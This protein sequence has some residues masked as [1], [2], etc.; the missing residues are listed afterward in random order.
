MKGKISFIEQ[1]QFLHLF[2]AVMLA[3][4]TWGSMGLALLC[5]QSMNCSLSHTSVLV[6]RDRQAGC[7]AWSEYAFFSTRLSS[8]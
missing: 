7:S 4:L 1:N 6:S 5:S 3:N 8:I 2:S